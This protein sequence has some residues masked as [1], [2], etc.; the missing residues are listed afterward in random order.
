MRYKGDRGFRCGSTTLWSFGHLAHGAFSQYQA[1]D[2]NGNAESAEASVVAAPSMA[3]MMEGQKIVNQWLA[4]LDYHV[5]GL[6]V[7]VSMDTS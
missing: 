7:I 1:P 6:C 3:K 2:T 4:S 5:L